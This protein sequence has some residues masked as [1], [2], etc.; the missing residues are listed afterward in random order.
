MGFHIDSFL[1]EGAYGKKSDHIGNKSVRDDEQPPVP[2]T[3]TMEVIR[4]ITK[5]DDDDTRELVTA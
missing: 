3:E 5:D 2:P 4:S 1:K